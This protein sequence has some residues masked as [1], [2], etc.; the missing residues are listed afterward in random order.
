ML[1]IKKTD[2]TYIFSLEYRNDMNN[3]PNKVEIYLE[4]DYLNKS[5]DIIPCPNLGY[6]FTFR[7]AKKNNR[8]WLELFE[9]MKTATEFAKKKLENE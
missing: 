3:K 1:E 7:K 9:C 5:F 6:E 4:I 8:K 2:S